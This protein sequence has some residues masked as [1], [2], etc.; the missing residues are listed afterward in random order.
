MI[1]QMPL[2]VQDHL[3]VVPA[4]INGH[5][6]HLVVDSGAERT[7][8]SETA[9]EPAG[10]APR[11]EA[12]SFSRSASAAPR[13]ATDVTIDRLVLGGVHFSR[14]TASPSAPST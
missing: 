13:T 10:P 2:Q 14:S 4:G 7:M 9:A 1:A 12:T 5:W 3:L 8:L 11:H 6:V